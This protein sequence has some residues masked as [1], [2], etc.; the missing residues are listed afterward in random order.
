[1]NKRTIV[2]SLNEIANELDSN[3]LFK[4]ANEVTEVMVKLSQNSKLDPNSAAGR[5]VYTPPPGSLGA[6]FNDLSQ[7]PPDEPKISDSLPS[8]D[9]PMP[10][11]KFLGTPSKPYKSDTKKPKTAEGLDRWVNKAENIY[12]AWGQKGANPNS[13]ALGMIVDIAV[14]MNKLKSNLPTSLHGQADTKIAKVQE[15]L[16]NIADGAYN[17]ALVSTVTP[18]SSMSGY[19]GKGADP[20]GTGPRIQGK[21]L[22]YQARQEAKSY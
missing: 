16:R 4:E 18:Y 2:A 6:Y 20:F 8:L 7:T 5:A 14:Y 19:P 3:G 21:Q 15:M 22:D 9:I 17:E 1:M 10:Y 13:S 12:K 11:D